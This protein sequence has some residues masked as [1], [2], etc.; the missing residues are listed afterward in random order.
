MILPIKVYVTYYFICQD[1]KI[2]Q[3]LSVYMDE[4]MKIASD[5][6]MR[7]RDAILAEVKHI[8]VKFVQTVAVNDMKLSEE[9]VS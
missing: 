7:R 9:E 2:D 5:E 8:F 3:T 6:E 1:K 4:N